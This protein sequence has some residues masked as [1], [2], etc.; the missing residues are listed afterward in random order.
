M[1]PPI[2]KMDVWKIETPRTNL[3][4]QST[5]DVVSQVTDKNYLYGYKGKSTQPRINNSA[6]G[7]RVMAWQKRLGVKAD[8]WWG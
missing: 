2:K 5:D 3:D 4:T 6:E 1:A 8:G 7:R